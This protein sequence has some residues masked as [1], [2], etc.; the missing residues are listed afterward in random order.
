MQKIEKWIKIQSGAEI[1]ISA[2]SLFTT[3]LH[4]HEG[5]KQHGQ[6]KRFFLLHPHDTAP[7]NS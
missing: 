7:D 4:N 5:R 6:R 2:P 1:F 3:I